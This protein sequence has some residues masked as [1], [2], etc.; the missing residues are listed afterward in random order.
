MH[1][2]MDLA[3]DA[4][5]LAARHPVDSIRACRVVQLAG[6]GDEHGKV[7]GK[8]SGASPTSLT[9]P[10]YKNGRHCQPRAQHSHTHSHAT[11]LFNRSAVTA[12]AR[13]RALVAA[14]AWRRWG[15]RCLWLSWWW[16]RAPGARRRCRA[17]TR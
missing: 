16:R 6:N 12:S 17:A 13:W 7:A 1:N 15:S 4:W 5:R 10:T 2:H 14:A 8:H 3:G 9:S 11:R